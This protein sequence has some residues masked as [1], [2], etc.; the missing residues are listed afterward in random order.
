MGKK[1]LDWLWLHVPIVGNLVREINSART[2]RTLSSLL[3]S[4]VDVIMAIEITEQVV[5]NTYFKRVIEDAKKVIQNG[6]AISGVFLKNQKLYPSF[7]GEMMSV[8]EETGKLAP[9]L[10]DVATYYE[11]E[12]DQKTKD[13]STIIEPILMIVIG[14]AVGFFAVSMI[15][16]MYSLVNAF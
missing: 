14:A 10:L 8:G 9:M 16:P 4:G 12:V 2:A 11:N 3:S 5:Q 6:E 13:M 15:T 7:V 1:A